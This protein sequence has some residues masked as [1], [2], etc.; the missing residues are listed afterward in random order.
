MQGVQGHNEASPSLQEQA[1]LA[2]FPDTVSQRAQRHVRELTALV[3]KGGK[4]ALL[5]IVQRSDCVAFAP[6]KE[7]DP[8]YA[9]LVAEAALAGVKLLAAA[10]TLDIGARRV[11]YCGQLPVLLDYRLLDGQLPVQEDA[12]RSLKKAKL[13]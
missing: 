11:R 8:E 1:R 4:A 12:S 3:R 2:L 6:C 10:V 5:F 9:S 7:K 13:S